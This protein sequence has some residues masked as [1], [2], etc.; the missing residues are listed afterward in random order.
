MIGR[1]VLVDTG[2]GYAHYEAIEDNVLHTHEPRRLHNDARSAGSRH[3]TLRGDTHTRS[4]AWPA[5]IIR[6]SCR[7]E[8]KIIDHVRAERLRQA[9]C[10]QLG[11]SDGH[12]V[13]TGNTRTALLS[14]IWIIVVV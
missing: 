12:G 6:V 1:V 3:E 14:G 2:D 11:A 13:E 8:V 10:E 9:Q 5:D 7:T 4:A